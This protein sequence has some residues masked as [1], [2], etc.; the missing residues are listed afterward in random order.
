MP[1]GISSNPSLIVKLKQELSVSCCDE[2]GRVRLVSLP[3]G[4]TCA[5]CTP[6]SSKSLSTSSLEAS[7]ARTSALQEMVRA[8][9]VSEADFLGKSSD[10][11]ENSIQLSFSL[12]T[13]P[14]SELGALSK[15]SGHLMASGMTVDG[16]LYQPKKL[17]PR[18]LEKD[19]GCLPTPA[20]VS[21]GSNKGGAAGRTGKTRYSLET[22]ASKNLWPP[23]SARDWRDGGYPAEG[24]RNTPTLAFQA[25]GKLNPQF[26]E[27]LIGVPTDATELE[28]WETAGCLRAPRK[29]SK[30]SS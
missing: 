25:G 21:Y 27:W 30:G 5:L 14:Q 1:S 24:K 8:W 15:W 26:V 13:S 22:M 6:G 20:A 7:R 23:E 19:G 4:T 9:R 17:E 3:S 29:R 18:T 16:Q 12:K 11:P 10:L 2:C 28:P